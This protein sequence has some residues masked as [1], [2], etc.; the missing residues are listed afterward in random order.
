[1]FISLLK[2]SQ[3]FSTG[4]KKMRDI[5]FGR[6][7]ADVELIGQ[8]ADMGARGSYLKYAMREM[9]LEQSNTL[10]AATRGA[11][12]IRNEANLIGGENVGG[13]TIESAAP[14][15]AAEDDDGDGDGDPDPD[16]RPKSRNATPLPSA[17]LL[18]PK[19]ACALLGIGRTKLW[20][21]SE[22]DPRFPRKI[23]LGPRCVGW[24]IDAL[25]GYLRT[26]EQ[27]G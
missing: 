26:L 12:S 24:R 27:E 4:E 5:R 16:R 11:L 18:R 15:V 20:Q 7:R 22:R 19:A 2:V 17:Q 14:E 1:L 23:V 21:L 8:L 9:G 6:S 25:N 13:E 10:W 3:P